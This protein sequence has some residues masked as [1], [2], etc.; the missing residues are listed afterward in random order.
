MKGEDDDKGGNGCVGIA[1]S[2]LEERGLQLRISHQGEGRVLP[3]RRRDE[4]NKD[5]TT[6]NHMRGVPPPIDGDI[7]VRTVWTQ[8][9]D[10]N[11]CARCRGG[12][13]WRKTGRLPQRGASLIEEAQK[14]LETKALITKMKEDQGNE[15]AEL[16]KLDKMEIIGGLKQTF[17]H[18]KLIEYLFKDPARAVEEMD[19]EGMIDKK[20]LKKYRKDTALLEQDTRRGLYF[21]FISLAVVGGFIE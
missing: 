8:Q 12:R 14:D 21:Q 19:K 11:V 20:H 16:R 1:V 6:T 17:D 5:K 7:D 2:K 4:S 13:G 18:L 9:R 15:L 3:Q 10:A